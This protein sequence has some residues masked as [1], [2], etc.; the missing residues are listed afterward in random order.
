ML[1]LIGYYIYYTVSGNPMPV[2][3]DGT[4]V[5][6]TPVDAFTGIVGK[7]FKVP[8]QLKD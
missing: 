5:I 8:T 3:G 1:Y 2:Y 7:R 4:Q 6:S